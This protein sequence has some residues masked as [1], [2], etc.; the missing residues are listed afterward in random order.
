MP[1]LSLLTTGV[2]SAS[3]QEADIARLGLAANFV[4][5]LVVGGLI[6]AVTFAGGAGSLYGIGFDLSWRL[7]TAVTSS[8]TG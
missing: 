4:V 7:S 8:V 2:I 5:F 3:D 6:A 1:P